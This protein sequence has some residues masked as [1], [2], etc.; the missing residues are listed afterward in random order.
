MADDKT[1][2]LSRTIAKD[3]NEAAISSFST[4]LGVKQSFEE[5][6]N[7]EQKAQ[8]LRLKKQ[9]RRK[10]ILSI[11]SILVLLIVVGSVFVYFFYISPI[12]IAKPY[13][14]KP[15]LS[16]DN[17][18][19]VSDHITYIVNELGGY[20]LHGG[21]FGGIAQMELFFPDINKKFTITVDKHHIYTV[22]GDAPNPDIVLSATEQVFIDMFRAEDLMTKAKET[23]KLEMVQVDPIVDETVLAMKGYKA[24]YDA[25]SGKIIGTSS[26]FKLTPAVKKLIYLISVIIVAILG[27]I[28]VTRN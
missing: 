27:I 23:V 17:P 24:I 18:S 16:E 8:K 21:P 7:P 5:E 1:E 15:F 19:I 14:E 20:K 2:F 26:L 25:L 6:I 13:I 28:Y 3:L 11:V 22:G 12:F 4:N 10:L 9:A